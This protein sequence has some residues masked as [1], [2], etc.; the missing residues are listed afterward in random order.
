MKTTI[1]AN[2]EKRTCL[3][4]RGLPKLVPT[5]VVTPEQRITYASGKTMPA[6]YCKAS[7]KD[8]ATIRSK[9]FPGIARAMAEQW[10]AL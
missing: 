9:T 1:Y 7:G 5:A 4:L 6:W 10:G 3:W 2:Y 8:R